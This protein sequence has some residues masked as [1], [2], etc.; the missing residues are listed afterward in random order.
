MVHH[1]IALSS[2]VHNPMDVK[3]L[4]KSNGLQLLVNIEMSSAK[5]V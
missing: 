5:M 4:P 2:T 1:Y 3:D